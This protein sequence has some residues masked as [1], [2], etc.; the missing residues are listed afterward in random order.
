MEAI[1]FGGTV[2]HSVHRTVLWN[3]RQMRKAP[4]KAEEFLWQYLRHDALGVRFRRQH[5]VGSKIL[6]FYNHDAKLGIELDG[7]IHDTKDQ[8]ILDSIKEEILQVHGIHVLRF[9]NEEVLQNPEAVISIIKKHLETHLP[10]PRGGRAGDGGFAMLHLG[11]VARLTADKGIDVLI[12]AIRNIPNVSL[13][14][15]GQ[16][17]EEGF[18]RNMIMDI[19][20]HENVTP[21]RISLVPSVSDLGEFYRSL[22][23]FILPS[24]EHDPFGLVAA[25]SMS[26]GIPTIVTDA[27]GIAGYLTDGKDAMLA[28]ADSVMDL[29]KAIESLKDPEKRRVLGEQGKLTAEKKF[30][31]EAMIQKYED[32][33]LPESIRVKSICMWPIG[34]RIGGEELLTM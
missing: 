13:T 15:V 29:Q 10:S 4:T 2:R 9:S 33:L 32:L 8:K 23:V 24:R 1:E 30:S 27:C 28:Q 20:D 25:E 19:T 11:T 21:S 12:E 6:D 18:L 16:G 17:K 34:K 26:L 3:A 5:P 14:I 7:S 31:V 22:D